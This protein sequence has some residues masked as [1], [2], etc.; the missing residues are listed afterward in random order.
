MDMGAYHTMKNLEQVVNELVK[1]LQECGPH[2][3]VVVVS[4]D[5]K[6]YAD[7]G[8]ISSDEYDE[9]GTGVVIDI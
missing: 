9:L 4:R 2:T 5:K 7:I 1:L 8:A 3:P 6:L